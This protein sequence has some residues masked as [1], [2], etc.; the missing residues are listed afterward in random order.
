MKRP[1]NALTRRLGMLLP[2]LIGLGLFA[3]FAFHFL[4]GD[5][6]IRT[7]AQLGKDLEAAAA[8]KAQLQHELDAARARVSSLSVKALDPDLLEERAQAVLN[9]ARP[10]EVVIILPESDDGGL[11][12][13]SQ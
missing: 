9:Y 11:P 5:R 6:G 8:E 2:Q 10:E 12:F 3:Y 13:Q 7:Y 4:Q 1:S